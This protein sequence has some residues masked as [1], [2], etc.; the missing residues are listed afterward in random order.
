MVRSEEF[1]EGDRDMVL[2]T[3]GVGETMQEVLARRWSRRGMVKGGLAAGLVLSMGRAGL[4]SA[5][6]Q[7]ATPGAPSAAGRTVVGKLAF[8]P[9]ALDAGD[10]LVV[11]PGHTAVP[12][13]R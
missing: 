11:A 10:A 13:L 4:R 9:I 12:F 8:E 7:D 1:Y 3:A 6:A 5:T 2:P